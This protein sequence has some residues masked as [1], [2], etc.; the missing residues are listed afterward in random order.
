MAAR[1]YDSKNARLKFIKSQ[2]G[3]L[4]LIKIY[5][6]TAKKQQTIKSINIDIS[7]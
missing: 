5:K 2:S 7:F 4:I 3:I 6:C 1:G